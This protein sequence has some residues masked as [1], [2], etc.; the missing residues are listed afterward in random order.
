M[1]SSFVHWQHSTVKR[2]WT[3]VSFCHKL[4]MWLWATHL[5]S[6]GHHFLFCKIKG[7]MDSNYF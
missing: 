7:Y 6:L 2:T 3:L 4:A 5:D 1:S